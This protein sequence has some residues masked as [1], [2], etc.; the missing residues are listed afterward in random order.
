[1]WASKFNKHV[2]Y[3]FLNSKCQQSLLIG[4]RNQ[5]GFR[6]QISIKTA[7]FGPDTYLINCSQKHFFETPGA[8]IPLEFTLQQNTKTV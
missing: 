3:S 8:T 7:L 2:K 6:M 1:M 5:A 4:R